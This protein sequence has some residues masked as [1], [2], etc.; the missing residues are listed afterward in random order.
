MDQK[1]ISEICELIGNLKEKIKYLNEYE[2]HI[3]VGHSNHKYSV[4]TFI[5]KEF[6]SIIKNHLAINMNIKLK[7]YE[8]KIKKLIEENDQ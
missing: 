8:D 2:T 3:H 7:K 1:K 4:T 6:M 5:D